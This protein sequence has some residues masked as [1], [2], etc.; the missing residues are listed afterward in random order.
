MDT[1]RWTRL[2]RIKSKIDDKRNNG[3]IKGIEEEN[4]V[5]RRIS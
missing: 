2:G 4:D 3:N 5:G 1:Y